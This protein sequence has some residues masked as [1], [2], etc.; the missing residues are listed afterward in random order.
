MRVK[1]VTIAVL[2]ALCL[3]QA[4]LAQDD[5]AAGADDA[6]DG[7][8][9]TTEEPEVSTLPPVF[10]V[11][12]F[13]VVSDVNEIDVRWESHPSF[14]DEVEGYHFTVVKE[15]STNV[16]TTKDLDS[17]VR[18]FEIEDLVHESD[19]RVCLY[20]QMKNGTEIERCDDFNT[21][22]FVR[23]DSLIILFCVLGYI[24][25]MILLGYFCWSYAKKKAEAEEE[26]EEEEDEEKGG[27]EALLA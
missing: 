15:G 25:L 5:N 3:F 26:E 8:D 13:H 17:D 18:S 2:A 20:T 21:I 1:T 14:N 22:A 7:E 6:G 4:V 10:D 9:N 27:Q 16:L 24:A 11:D 12:L 19:Y 23:D